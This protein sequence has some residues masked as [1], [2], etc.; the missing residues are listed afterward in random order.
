MEHTVGTTPRFPCCFCKKFFTNITRHQRRCKEGEENNRFSGRAISERKLGTSKCQKCS[1]EFANISRHQKLCKGPK[2]KVKC[3]KFC[4]KEILNINFQRHLKTCKNASI[5]NC[6]LCPVFAP[7]EE[8]LDHHVGTCH[9]EIF[10][11]NIELDND[12]IFENHDD[13]KTTKEIHENDHHENHD[14]QNITKE[15]HEKD[16]HEFLENTI[17]IPRPKKRMKFVSNYNFQTSVVNN[18]YQVPKSIQQN[19]NILNEVCELVKCKNCSSMLRCY[20]EIHECLPD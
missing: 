2:V 9:V 14:E 5:F 18:Y 19:L 11:Q 15:I 16:D 7:N 4:G 20:S 3:P 17:N 13:Q 1:G 10:E 8:A 6:V 12:E